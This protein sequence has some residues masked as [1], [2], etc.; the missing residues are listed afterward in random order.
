[1]ILLGSIGSAIYNRM[2][3]LLILIVA[4][5]A[6]AAPDP[7]MPVPTAT[8]TPPTNQAVTDQ[9]VASYRTQEALPKADKIN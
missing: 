1:M 8:P 7:T 6:C 9:D 2:K 3:L 5:V 4:M